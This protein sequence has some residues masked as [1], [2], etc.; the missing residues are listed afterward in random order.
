MSQGSKAGNLPQLSK[1]RLLLCYLT[2]NGPGFQNLVRPG[3]D[4]K[5]K[6][7]EDIF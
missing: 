1:I 4:Y 2:M 6:I 5:R 3:A 7:F